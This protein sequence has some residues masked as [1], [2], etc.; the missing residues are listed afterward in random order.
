MP[1]FRTLANRTVDFLQIQIWR[2]DKNKLTR[3]VA[4]L[5]RSLQVF[6]TAVRGYI[7]DNCALHASALTFYSLLSVVPVAAMAFG[8]AKGFGLEQRLEKLLYLRFA[9][10]EEVL[11][12]IIDFARSLLE[13]TKGGLIAGIGVAVL[14]WSSI[15]VMSH[16]ESTLNTIW[17]VSGRSFIRKFTDYL[18]ILIISPL[19]VIVS[20]S[21]NVFIK[22]Q[23]L[24][25]TERWTMLEAAGPF[26][27]TSLKILPFGLI[28]LLFIMIYLVMPNTHVRFRSALIAGI[29]GGSL[30]QLVQGIY[31]SAQVVVS[32]YNAIYGSFA[33]LPLFL[34]WMQ[35]SWMVVLFGAQIAHAH[36][37]IGRFSMG[38]DFQSSRPEFRKRCALH[39]LHWIIRQFGDGAAPPTGEQI[40]RHLVLPDAMVEKLLEHLR[41]CSLIS[42]VT[43]D[44]AD[45]VAY[46]PAK[47][48]HTITIASVLDAL[49][50]LGQPA[51]SANQLPEF[52]AIT[53][54]V[55]AMRDE[56]DRSPAN[57]L[58]KDIPTIT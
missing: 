48:I 21:V 6:V 30:Y 16:I 44:R 19:L 55:D 17:R 15:K 12:K 35:I 52:E 39:I 50:R 27:L 5:L 2:Y 9:G 54:A 25:A 23:I 40:S 47:D 1:K 29:I 56:M 32:S 22:T 28:W 18:A 7:K 45:G 46:Q 51:I 24:A 4:L 53:Q 57:I 33:A 42:I 20:G 10:Q 13:N 36:Q 3:P 31:I 43:T 34:I 26:I 37:Y 49:D 8:I 11:S 58:V 38:Y 14:F 41:Q